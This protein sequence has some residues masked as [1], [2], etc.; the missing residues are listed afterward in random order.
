M[1]SKVGTDSGGL[2]SHREIELFPTPARAS[3]FGPL[4]KAGWA[5]M[6]RRRLA[7]NTRASSVT[8]RDSIA[9]AFLPV[10]GADQSE[11][12]ESIGSIAA[13]ARESGEKRFVRAKSPTRVLRA[14]RRGQGL[15]FSLG[16]RRRLPPLARAGGSFRR[17]W[18]AMAARAGALFGW[19]EWLQAHQLREGLFH[20]P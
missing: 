12:S 7:T 5:S 8:L 6:R 2:A 11:I 9:L 20:R 18:W 19:W 1:E 10:F 4:P 16:S 15:P 13:I 3:S 17:A 14:H